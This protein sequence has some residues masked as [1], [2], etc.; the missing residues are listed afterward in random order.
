MRHPMTDDSKAGQGW[1]LKQLEDDP[2]AND[3]LDGIGHHREHAPH[4]IAAEV[5]V[6]ERS[7]WDRFRY[8]RFRFLR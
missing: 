7:K 1:G 4:K 8:S 5:S 2:V 3:M 6:A